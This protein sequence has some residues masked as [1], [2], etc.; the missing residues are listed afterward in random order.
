VCRIVVNRLGGYP[1]DDCRYESLQAEVARHG[2]RTLPRDE[3]EIAD[4]A[5]VCVLV[6]CSPV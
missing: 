6:T 2:A 3:A 1:H 5:A 4:A